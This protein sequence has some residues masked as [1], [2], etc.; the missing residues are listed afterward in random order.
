MLTCLRLFHG[1]EL[2]EG[3]FRYRKRGKAEPR[4]LT[5]FPDHTR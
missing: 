2:P 1:G 5:H 3:P 4:N